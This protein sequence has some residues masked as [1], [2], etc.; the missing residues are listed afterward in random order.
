M[1]SGVGVEVNLGRVAI[2]IHECPRF[3]CSEKVG[4]VFLDYRISKAISSRIQESVNLSID[5]RFTLLK[6]FGKFVLCNAFEMN[7]IIQCEIV[8]LSEYFNANYVKM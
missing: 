5:S 2:D 8:P 4:L 7:E 6:P 1:D 3:Q